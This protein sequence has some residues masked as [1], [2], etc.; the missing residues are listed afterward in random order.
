M[1]YRLATVLT[2]ILTFL[3]DSDDDNDNGIYMHAYRYAGSLKIM[4][5]VRPK[6]S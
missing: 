4:K 3:C 5:G 6:M 1:L 2:K